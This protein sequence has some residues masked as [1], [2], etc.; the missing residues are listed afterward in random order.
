MALSGKAAAYDQDLMRDMKIAQE[1]H[2]ASLTKQVMDFLA[3][4]SAGTGLT[5]EEYL[6]F[7]LYNRPRAEYGSFMGDDRARA[8]FFLAN[9]L[10]DWNVA[11][12]KIHFAEA[13]QRAG[14]SSPKTLAVV[15]RDRTL[16][17]VPSFHSPEDI[18]VF[19]ASCALPVFGKPA[20]A[21]HGDGA[22]KIVARDGD[23]LTADS[24]EAFT[25]AELAAEISVYVEDDG[26]LFQEALDPH[27]AIAEITGGRIASLRLVAMLG[28][29]GVD[30]RFGVLRLPAGD[31]RVDNFRRKGNL[32][33]AIDCETGVAG[34]AR[35]GFGVGAETMSAHPDTGAAIEGVVLPDFERAKSVV[36][37]AAAQ[38]PTLHLQS[39][40]V[41]L[42]TTGPSLLEVNPG[43]NF[44][45]LQ[46]AL[47]RGVFDPEFRRFLE[48]RLQENPNARVNPKALKEAKKLFRF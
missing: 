17:G 13:M 28:P 4:R 34:G 37:K 45:I 10:D 26:Y 33:A 20:I 24:G 27:P 16:E 31:N 40:D 21:S 22:V 19:L 5:F 9:E 8:A 25:G 47:G 29:E 36:A 14:L 38:F 23:R 48:W 7:E 6:F 3:L 44:N 41:A 42:A 43:G 15:H 11:E 12:D 39:W 2:G 46:L 1:R 18:E 30:I 35:R 32:I